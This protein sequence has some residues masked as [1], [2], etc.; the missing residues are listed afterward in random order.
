MENHLKEE[1][2]R[3]LVERLYLHV[4]AMPWKDIGFQ[5]SEVAQQV[6]HD[7]I[8]NLTVREIM[9]LQNEEKTNPQP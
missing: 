3:A 8:V 4:A 5:R 6:A 1:D 2:V 7:Q 9:E